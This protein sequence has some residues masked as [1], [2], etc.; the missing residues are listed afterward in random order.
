MT[1]SYVPAPRRRLQVTVNGQATLLDG[2]AAGGRLA[3]VTIP[4]SLTPGFNTVEMGYPYGWAPDIDKF[5]LR[6]VE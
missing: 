6:P 4:V 1:I 2:L 5:E 3:T